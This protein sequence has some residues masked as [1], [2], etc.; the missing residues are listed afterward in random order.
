MSAAPTWIA[1]VGCCARTGAGIPARPT[2][3]AMAATLA[4]K[5]FLA[6]KTSLGC[7]PQ[8]IWRPAR[9][10]LGRNVPQ[11]AVLPQGESVTRR[12]GVFG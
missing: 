7:C 5:L 1:A 12:R 2:V 6:M 10:L 11:L 8:P 9:H 4:Y 3:S